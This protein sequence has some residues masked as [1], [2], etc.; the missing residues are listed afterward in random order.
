MREKPAKK[1]KTITIRIDE[2]FRDE[3]DAQAEKAGLKREPFIRAILEQVLAD[4]S[5]VL[6]LKG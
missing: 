4:K 5:F 1:P 3:I 6:R 2:S